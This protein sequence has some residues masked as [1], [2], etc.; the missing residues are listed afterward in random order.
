MCIY[1]H[2]LWGLR[3][4]YS[5]FLNEEDKPIKNG[6]MCSYREKG[7]S[8][9]QLDKLKAQINSMKGKTLQHIVMNELSKASSTLHLLPIS[10]KWHFLV[11]YLF[12]I[13]WLWWDK[14]S[15]G[16]LHILSRT[17]NLYVKKWYPFKQSFS[18]KFERANICLILQLGYWVHLLLL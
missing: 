11:V 3:K 13:S 17:Y 12:D 2:H 4:W 8:E 7:A 6:T 10:C 5:L 1:H 14:R 9:L 18:I 15:S 16:S